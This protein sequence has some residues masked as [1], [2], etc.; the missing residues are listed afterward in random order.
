MF[1][2]ELICLHV[3]ELFAC[4]TNLKKK[5]IVRKYEWISNDTGV[6]LFVTAKKSNVETKDIFSRG[7]FLV[8]SEIDSCAPAIV[9]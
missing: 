2:G 7:L 4:E 3:F 5:C 1:F 9:L 6:R 8:I